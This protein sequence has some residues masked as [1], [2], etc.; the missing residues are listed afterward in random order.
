MV[1]FFSRF[2]FSV[3]LKL[4]FRM[5]VRGREYVPKKGPF[6]LASNH[7][8]YLDPAA[9]GVACPRKLN[10]MARHDLFASPLA[11]WWLYAVGC[12]P[13]KRN[14]TDLSAFRTAVKKLENGEGLLLFPEGKRQDA[15]RIAAGLLVEPEPG[16]GMLASKLGVPVIPA[17]VRGTEEAF[18][19]GAKFIMPKKV[20]IYFGKQINMERGLP[21]QNAA[22]LIMEKVRHLACS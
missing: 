6:I 4:A 15:S 22:N 10:Y 20:F 19:K 14:S 12:F 7:V 13:V 1:Y 5:K 21:Y 9:L 18:P 11:S 17:F 2:I 8:S 3:I 16:I